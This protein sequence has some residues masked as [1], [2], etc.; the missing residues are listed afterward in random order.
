MILE[1]NEILIVV[2]RRLFER[3]RARFFI[4]RVQGCD[5]G[6]ARV[7]GTTWTQDTFNGRFVRKSDERTKLIPLQSGAYLVYVLPSDLDINH[8]ELAN[9]EQGRLWLRDRKGWKMDL[10]ENQHVGV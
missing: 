10:T 7:T 6:V 1:T 4:G 5:A 3:D 2:N 8:L 9:D